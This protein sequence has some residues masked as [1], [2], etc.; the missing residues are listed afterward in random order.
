[1]TWIFTN[2]MLGQQ[3]L[4]E[5][6]ASERLSSTIASHVWVL[7]GVGGVQTLWRGKLASDDW[8]NTKSGDQ[9]LPITTKCLF[10]IPTR[11]SLSAVQ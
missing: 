7:G 10:T 11:C 8:S 2:N 1:M 4:P 6:P 9:L 3:K 5:T